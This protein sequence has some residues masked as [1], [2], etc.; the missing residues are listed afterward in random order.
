MKPLGDIMR[1]QNIILKTLD[2]ITSGGF[3]QVPNFILR[4]PKLPALEAETAFLRINEVS[5]DQVLR[6]AQKLHER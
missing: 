4:D 1:E 5:A 6:D 2:P 3:T